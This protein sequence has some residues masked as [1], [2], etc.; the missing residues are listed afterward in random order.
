M[1]LGAAV[2]SGGGQPGDGT[3][4][5]TF[6]RD[7]QDRVII[8][9]SF[10]EYPASGSTPASRHDDVTIVYGT[11]SGVRADYYDSEG[12]VIHYAVQMPAAGVAVF[13]SDLVS[14]EP[15]YRLSY[16]LMPTG[17]VEG[18]FEIAGPGRTAFTPYLTWESKKA[19]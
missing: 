14:G 13:L 12:H 6:R 3:G 18:A 7:L 4:A 10:A 8:R 2:S 16:R 15:R 11:P 17:L 1:T 5:A 19:M 9:T